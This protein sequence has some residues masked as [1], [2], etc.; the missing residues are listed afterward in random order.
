MEPPVAPVEE[1]EP[2]HVEKVGPAQAPEAPIATPELQE[3]LAHIKSM[4]ESLTQARLILV[5]Q[6]TSQAVG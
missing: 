6:A 3:T 1:Y 2:D 4:F 5:M